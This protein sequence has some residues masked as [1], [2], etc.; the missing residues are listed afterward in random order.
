MTEIADAGYWA[1]RE[2]FLYD[3]SVIDDN[4]DHPRPIDVLDILNTDKD[5]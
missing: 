1:Y 4:K 5:E 3:K 2:R